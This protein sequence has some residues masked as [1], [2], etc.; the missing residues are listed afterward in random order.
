M[1]YRRDFEAN[2]LIRNGPGS[3]PQPQMVVFTVALTEGRRRRARA[4]HRRD[5]AGHREQGKVREAS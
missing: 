4:P 1:Q 5:S 2:R 3:P